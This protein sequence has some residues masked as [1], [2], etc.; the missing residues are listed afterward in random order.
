MHTC[1][2]QRELNEADDCTQSREDILNSNMQLKNG[3]S[4]LEDE[5]KEP[6]PTTTSKSVH[7]AHT[8][9][10]KK[11]KSKLK[12]GKSTNESNKE[13]SDNHVRIQQED[14]QQPKTKTS[15]VVAGDSILKY[16]KG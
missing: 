8:L 5:V 11:R 4:A 15:V 14:Q 12:D 16:V 6:D 1:E 10:K 13:L 7:Q 3:F 2:D 9:G